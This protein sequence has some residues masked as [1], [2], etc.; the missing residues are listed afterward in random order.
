MTAREEFDGVGDDVV[1]R[2]RLRSGDLTTS[3]Q[4]RSDA[5]SVAERVAALDG[6]LECIVCGAL[7]IGRLHKRAI[8]GGR[9]VAIC[10]DCAAL[11]VSICE[12]HPDLRSCVGLLALNVERAAQG[13][14][15]GFFAWVDPVSGVQRDFA[16]TA[17]RIGFE[18]G[19]GFY[20]AACNCPAHSA[21]RQGKREPLALSVRDADVADVPLAALRTFPREWPVQVEGVACTAS[22]AVG[23]REVVNKAETARPPLGPLSQAALR[24]A[25]Q[26]A[27]AA[28][29]RV[30]S[31]DAVARAYWAS[32][33]SGTVPRALTRRELRAMGID[34]KTAAG[35]AEYGRRFG[36]ADYPPLPSSGGLVR[37]VMPRPGVVPQGWYR[38]GPYLVDECGECHLVGDDENGG[39]RHG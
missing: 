15:N 5:R 12:Y 23:E 10:A 25:T 11:A 18:F 36:S 21:V 8:V 38:D 37:H 31:T 19:R 2:A 39:D 7:P 30:G 26:A 35:R 13:A 32:V 22:E 28:W 1:A 24:G 16:R 6:A 3:V 20:A 17:R 34:L 33:V 4:A 27:A 14:Y 9:D 29:R